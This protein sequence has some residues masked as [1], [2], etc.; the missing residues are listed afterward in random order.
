LTTIA[1]VDMYQKG[2]ITADHL[3][4]QCLLLIDPVDPAPVLSAL[5][6]E[7]LIKVLEFA[8][9]YVHNGM[10]TNYGDPPNPD[11]IN[12][13]KKWIEAALLSDPVTLRNR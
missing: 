7:I 13:A 2:A 4:V 5:P 1:L 9:R 11:Q 10:A 8:R 3:V 12:A 6:H